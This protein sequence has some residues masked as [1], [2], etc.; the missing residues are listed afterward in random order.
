MSVERN[1]VEK[2]TVEKTSQTSSSRAEKKPATGAG[3][4]Q[5]LR[6]HNQIDSYVFT[7]FTFLPYG[8]AGGNVVLECAKCGHIELLSQTSP[9]L[10]RLN[11]KPMAVGDGD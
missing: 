11:A 7:R 8:S 2:R 4:V 1:A 5:C 9:L 3:G 6:C 10:R